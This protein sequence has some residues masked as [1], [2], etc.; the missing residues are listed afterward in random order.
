[1]SVPWQKSMCGKYF[2]N[3]FPEAVQLTD[4]K[5]NRIALFSLTKRDKRDLAK[6]LSVYFEEEEDSTSIPNDKNNALPKMHK[7]TQAVRKVKRITGGQNQ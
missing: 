4:S 2:I 6:W 7:G 5:L 3:F 1:M